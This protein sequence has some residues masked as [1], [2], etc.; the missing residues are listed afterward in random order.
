MVRCTAVARV[1]QAVYQPARYGVTTSA[2]RTV[3]ENGLDGHECKRLAPWGR[4]RA[5]GAY[6]AREAKD[7]GKTAGALVIVPSAPRYGVTSP[8][9]MNIA[10]PPAVSVNE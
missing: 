3:L 5:D 7:P 6:V 4:R 8:K 1:T 2:A 9:S 10:P